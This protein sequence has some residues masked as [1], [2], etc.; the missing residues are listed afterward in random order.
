VQGV[1]LNMTVNGKD[2]VVPMVLEEPS[3]VAA[4]GNVARMTRP[5]GFTATSDDPVMVRST[6]CLDF[7]PWHLCARLGA[8]A[9]GGGVAHA[10]GACAVSR[11][12]I[13]Q[14]HIREVP[15]MKG[16]KA[17]LEANFSKLTDMA[18]EIQP[19]LLKRGEQPAQL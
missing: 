6:R 2:Y 14:I 10:L 13:G 15:D 8:H 18:N 11:E 7:A 9:L 19:R 17:T 4:V 16:A 1:A 3:V 5:E 12:Q